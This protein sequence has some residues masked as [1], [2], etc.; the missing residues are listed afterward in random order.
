MPIPLHYQ[1]N[2]NS[3][4]MAEVIISVGAVLVKG[5][6]IGVIVASCVAIYLVESRGVAKGA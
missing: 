5:L 2:K 3:K 6:A 4:I 1:T